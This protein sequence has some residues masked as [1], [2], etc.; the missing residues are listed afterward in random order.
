MKYKK[1][2]KYTKKILP[3]IIMILVQILM[4]VYMNYQSEGEVVN[5]L[6]HLMITL[7]YMWPAFVCMMAL[8]IGMI[9]IS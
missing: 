7:K 2:K 4:L 6:R 5:Q 3:I 1:Y 8:F 9:Y